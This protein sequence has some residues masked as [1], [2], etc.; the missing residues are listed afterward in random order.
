LQED[1]A[2]PGGN[3]SRFTLAAS[4]TLPVARQRMQA[5]CQTENSQYPRVEDPNTRHRDGKKRQPGRNFPV[6]VGESN[7]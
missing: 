2:L 4:L 3:S 1:A 5:S 7:R 6:G